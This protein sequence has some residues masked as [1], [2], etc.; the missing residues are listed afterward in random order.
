MTWSWCW[1]CV[2][3]DD[4]ISYVDEDVPG[5]TPDFARCGPEPSSDMDTD[6]MLY[7]YY[8]SDGGTTA[9]V[10]TDQPCS[11]DRSERTTPP[12]PRLHRRIEAAAS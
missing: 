6:H 3:E 10:V 5:R 9:V 2:A 1:A 4:A 8:C 11:D 12:L 7:Y